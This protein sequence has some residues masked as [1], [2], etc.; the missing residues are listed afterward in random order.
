[1]R[2]EVGPCAIE[3]PASLEPQAR[4]LAER[5]RGILP[6]LTRRLGAEPAA[7]FRILLI[8]NGDIDDAEAAAIDAR[9]PQW[10]AGYMIPSMRIGGIRVARAQRYPYGTIESVFAHE[11]AHLVLHDGAAGNLPRW[12]DEGAA[13]QEGRR[14]GV[15]DM[16]L[17]TSTLLTTSLPQMDDLN[18]AF[19]G[20][21]GEARVAYAA[22]F[23]FVSW[24]EKRYGPQFIREVVQES[25]VIPFRSA[26]ERAA[27]MS[28]VDS[29]REWRGDTL[30]RYRW[31]PIV[32][33]AS[34]LWALIGVLAFV[35]GI[36]KKAKQRATRE[37]W[38]ERERLLEQQTDSDDRGRL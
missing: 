38:A 21:E 35:G 19:Q 29:E 22:S 7:P 6:R 23:A 25:R 33:A 27:D 36:R 4:A 24:A 8:P 28:L 16:I 2:I 5:A 11:V 18:A 17:H 12:F 26:W 37:A 13:T 32:A 34:M 3:A 14:W 10:A 1:M 9:A 20:G 30:L 31:V 15:Q